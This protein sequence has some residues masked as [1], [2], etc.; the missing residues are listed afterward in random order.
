MSK[1]RGFVS[2]Q[3]SPASTKEYPLRAGLSAWCAPSPSSHSLCWSPALSTG[4]KE[5]SIPVG[6]NICGWMLIGPL[7]FST[8]FLISVYGDKN[9]KS[10]RKSWRELTA[11]WFRMQIRAWKRM[12]IDRE[13]SLSSMSS[14]WVFHRL[15][16]QL[17]PSNDLNKVQPTARQNANA[18]HRVAAPGTVTEALRYLNYIPPIGDKTVLISFIIHC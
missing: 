14:F 15:D 2:P 3:V 11:K 8:F 5:E 16:T 9:Q 10:S 18:A 13:M 6:A 7:S 17:F 1:S 12:C 4:I